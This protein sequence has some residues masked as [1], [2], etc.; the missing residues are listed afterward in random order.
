MAKQPTTDHRPL[1]TDDRRLAQSETTNKQTRDKRQLP[2]LSSPVSWSPH[3]LRLLVVGGRWSVVAA[4]ALLLNGCLL[5]S[6]EQSTT[7]TQATSGN[8]NTTFVSAEGGQ[9]RTIQTGVG[10][11]TLSVI[12]WVRVQQGE[13]RI[14]LLDPNG[15]VAIS[16]QGRPDE[17]ITKS[18][19]VPTDSEGNLRYRVIAR[20]ARNG[21]FQVLYQLAAP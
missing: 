20:G 1:T 17:Q 14:E 21:G 5:M 7:D 10:S 6:G 12:A 9:E 13:L 2:N 16:I 8:F 15:A 11:A 19:N 4:L 3:L 18:G